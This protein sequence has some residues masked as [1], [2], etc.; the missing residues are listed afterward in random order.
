[1]PSHLEAGTL[2]GHGIAG[3]NASLKYINKVGVDSIRTKEQRLTRAFYMKLKELSAIKIYG[4]FASF[5]RA[6]TVAF[7]IGEIES[8]EIC[9]RLEAEYGI[10]VRGGAHCAPLMHKAL[11]TEKQGAVRFSF[12]HYNTLAE[13]KTAVNA[14]TELVCEYR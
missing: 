11:G 13:I 10:C 7:N 14:L 5:D 9:S 12:S 3:L 8:G 6:P 1:M 2:N 4:D